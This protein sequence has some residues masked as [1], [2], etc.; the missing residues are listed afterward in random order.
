MIPRRPSVLSHKPYVTASSAG[1]ST[2]VYYPGDEIS[3]TYTESVLRQCN[4]GTVAVKGW[5]AD[6]IAA[7]LSNISTHPQ[8]TQEMIYVCLDDEVR[9][10][11]R[12][13]LWDRLQGQYVAVQVTDV[14]DV[15]HNPFP[16][17]SAAQQLTFHVASFDV[18]QSLVSITGL[19]FTAPPASL[20]NQLSTSL[21]PTNSSSSS[22]GSSST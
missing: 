10:D 6:S 4:E 3:I 1:S 8:G 13:P 9:I 17:S 14:V 20:A 11:F 16:P 12:S 18:T 2:P 19:T 15:A 7:L 5:Y 22:S 21:T